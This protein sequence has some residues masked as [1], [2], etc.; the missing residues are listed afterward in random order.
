MG[1]FFTS[2]QGN[3][4]E[5]HFPV[6]LCRDDSAQAPSYRQPL[7]IKSWQTERISPITGLSSF[8]WQH[9]ESTI[10]WAHARHVLGRIKG[11]LDMSLEN[12][13]RLFG[14][15]MEIASRDGASLA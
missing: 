4:F 15:M 8:D 1:A 10:S 5:L 12:D 13:L 2:A 14:Q 6:I 9:A 7:L 3:E 11:K